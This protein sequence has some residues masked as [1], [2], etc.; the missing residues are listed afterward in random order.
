MNQSQELDTNQGIDTKK[1]PANLK[2]LSG[3]VNYWDLVSYFNKAA[4]SAAGTSFLL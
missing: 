1:I 4:N 2:D 3:M